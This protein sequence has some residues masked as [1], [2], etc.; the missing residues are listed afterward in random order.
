MLHT[1]RPVAARLGL[2]KDAL[3]ERPEIVRAVLTLTRPGD[4]DPT[5]SPA[6]YPTGTSSRRA[7]QRAERRTDSR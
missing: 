1:N 7:G 5:C 3:H 4:E 6:N 2:T